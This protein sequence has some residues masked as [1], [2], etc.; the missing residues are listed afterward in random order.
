MGASFSLR[1]IKDCIKTKHFLY[2]LQNRPYLKAIE[3]YAQEGVNA[4][5]AATPVDSG[6]TASSWYYEITPGLVNTTIVWKNS[7]VTRDGDS[8]AIMLQYGHGTGTGGYVAGRDYIN[9][10]IQPVFDRIEEGVWEV[11]QNL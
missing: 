11:I 3:A 1:T 7:N 8:I 10:A 5:A 2:Q 6:K 4:L 9:P